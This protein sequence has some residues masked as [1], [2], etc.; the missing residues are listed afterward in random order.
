MD[1]SL[2]SLL[3]E[4][5]QKYAIPLSLYDGKQVL[6]FQQNT[7]CFN[8]LQAALMNH[9]V[10]YETVDYFFIN[11]LI[12]SSFDCHSKNDTTLSILIGPCAVQNL[13][14]T[15]FSSDAQR[16][17]PI[18]TSNLMQRKEFISFTSIV[19]SLLKHSTL[20][21]TPD[22][23][24][25]NET[26][27]EIYRFLRSSVKSRREANSFEDSV[28]LEKH[29]LD[30]VRRNK[31]SAVEWIISKVSSTYSAQLS[32]NSLES[33]KYKCVGIITLL[34]RISINSGVSA[35]RAYSLSDSLI[36][37][38]DQILSFQ[39]CSRFMKEGS[40]MFMELI[41]NSPYTKK[42]DLVKKILY[43]IDSNIYNKITIEE[44]SQYTGRHKTYI[45]SEFKKEMNQTI[46]EYINIKKVF[47]AKH[48]LILTNQSYKDIS[49]TLN[50]SSQS[51]FNRVFKK[52][53]GI[54]PAR[55]RLKNN[56]KF[57]DIE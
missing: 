45:S 11:G 17:I 44:I 32:M 53:E 3:K 21:P 37:T 4:L 39:D 15:K 43:Y 52:I 36:K 23:L 30:A 10:D 41:H 19:Y 9:I 40:F 1:S 35:M 20:P 25:S 29:F 55:Y 49:L 56:F 47:E 28:D 26:L 6:T 50:F 8:D 24:N 13:I 7:T 57:I 16:S 12:C 46:H 33:A 22:W 5:A 2:K 18:F 34:T 14:D 31:P 38:I 54:S 42:N 48:L 51:H 27:D